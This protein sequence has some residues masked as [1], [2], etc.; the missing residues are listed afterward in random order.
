VV[1][2]TNADGAFEIELPAGHLYR[3]LQAS[4]PGYLAGQ[5]ALPNTDLDTTTLPAGDVTGDQVIDIFDLAFLGSRYAQAHPLADINGDGIVDIIDLA[6]VATN[7]RRTGPVTL[8]L[9][10]Q[11]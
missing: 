3:C 7:Y 2:V 5:A 9:D 11:L 4:Q 10:A 1:A 6:L 8:G